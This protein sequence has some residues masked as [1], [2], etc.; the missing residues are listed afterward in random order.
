M[1]SYLHSRLLTHMKKKKKRV[2][3]GF[4]RAHKLKHAAYMSAVYV[5]AHT[6]NKE[7]AITWKNT[8]KD[9]SECVF[10][11]TRKYACTYM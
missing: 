10:D 7:V 3:T 8:W 4:I 1:V 9:L 11:T 5:H 2:F 6:P